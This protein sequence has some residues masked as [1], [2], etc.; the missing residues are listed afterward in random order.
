MA[1]KQMPGQTSTSSEELAYMLLE[2]ARLRCGSL[3][4]DSGESYADPDGLSL[5]GLYGDLGTAGYHASAR[6]EP[7]R[8]RQLLSQAYA[9]SERYG[10]DGG[11]ARALVDV[12]AAATRAVERA[13]TVTGLLD[14]MHVAHIH[15]MS[16]CD[17]L[18]SMFAVH[19]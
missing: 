7:A 6:L 17:A 5:H 8:R 12:T 16:A 10:V 1:D 9:R 11:S 3:L 4:D 15:V 14:H 13:L 18:D 19:A 2:E